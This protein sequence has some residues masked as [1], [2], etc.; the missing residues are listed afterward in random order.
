MYLQSGTV[1]T[2]WPAHYTQLAHIIYQNSKVHDST[3]IFNCI[4]LKFEKLRIEIQ[5]LRVFLSHR[6]SVI[7]E[8]N[9]G[10]AQKIR[11]LFKNI[12]DV[13]CICHRLALACSDTGDQYKFIQNIEKYLLEL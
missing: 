6:A 7:M 13:Y 4:S 5:K 10:A 9:G 11:A 12:I 2:I 1:K 8:D 3:S